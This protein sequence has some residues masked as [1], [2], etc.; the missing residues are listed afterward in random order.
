MGCSGSRD[1][2]QTVEGAHAEEN[3]CFSGECAIKLHSVEYRTFQAA[4]KR[5]GYRINMTEEH[6]QAIA[7]D[8]NLD[9]NKMKNDAKSAHAIAYLDKDFSYT[10]NK[11]NVENLILIGWLLCK[12]W[13]DQT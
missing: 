2:I 8:I 10:E 12:H 1:R 13:S 11:H 5:F 4:V 6:M 9:V 7:Q 3:Y